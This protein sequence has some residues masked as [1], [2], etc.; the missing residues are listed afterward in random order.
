LLYWPGLTPGAPLQKQ[1]FSEDWQKPNIIIGFQAGYFYRRAFQLALLV[2][3]SAGSLSTPKAAIASP[4]YHEHSSW[5]TETTDG[6]ISST[7]QGNGE[8]FLPLVSSPDPNFPGPYVGSWPMAGANP[9]RTSWTPT[10]VRGRLKP[11]WYKPFEAYISQ[12]VQIVAEYGKLYISTARGLYSLDAQTGSEKWVYPTELSLGH[13]PTVSDGV[14]YV[15]GYDRKIHAIDAQSGKGL[16]TFS[17]SAGFDT[18]PLV[19]EGLVLAGNR[20]GYFYAINAK[21]AEKG[22]LA[23]KFKTNGPILYSA[24]Y[25]NGVVYF[26]SEDSY[27]YALDVRSGNLLWKSDKLPGAGF[28]SWWPVVYNDIVI[29][30]GSYNYRAVVEP[31]L[32]GQFTSVEL[33]D[34][35]PNHEKDP[36]GTL[37]GQLG[38]EPGL[39]TPGTPT[40]NLSKPNTTP[41]G[42][43]VPVTE[44]F[45]AKP[46]RR[47]YLVLDRSTGKEIS[48][49]FDKDGKREYAPILW[50]G[51]QSG[52]RYP[53]AVG[54]DS[55]L[56]QGNNYRSDPYIAGGHISGWVPGSPYISVVKSGW[57]AVDEPVAFA[58]G[59]RLLYWNRCCDRIAGAFDVTI[60][61]RDALAKGN[62]DDPE[63]SWNY[64]SY[65]LPQI[66]PGYNSMTYVT[67]P[68]DYVFGGAYGGKNGSYGFHG[69]VNPPI[70]YKGM[71]FMHRSNAI[72]A[73]G[74][75]A[76]N[77]VKLPNA[78][79]VDVDNANIPSLSN[80]QIKTLLKTEIKKMIAAGHL[81]PGYVNNGMFDLAARQICGPDLVDYFHSPADTIYTLMLA[82]PYLDSATQNELAGYIKAE[83][84]Q[85][86]PYQYE[87]IGWRDGSGREPFILPPEVNAS[88]AGSGP[89]TAVYNFPGWELSPFT[90]YALWKYAYVFGDARS[91]FNSAKARLAPVPSDSVLMEMPYIHNAFI[92]GY[93]GYLELE[94]LA[95]YPESA[96]IRT[97]LNQLIDFRVNTFSK[98]A[99][100]S[101]FQ[102]YQKPYCRNL[103]SSRNFIFLV[104]ELANELR[105]RALNK[106]NP[107]IDEYE[108]INPLWFAKKTET[109]LG[110]G[111]IDQLYT[112]NALF[113]AKALIQGA[114]RQELTK[115]LD[116][117]A[118]EVGDLFYIQNLV[119]LIGT[120]LQTS[121]IETIPDRP[122]HNKK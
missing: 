39:W 2:V 77:P 92:A 28:H 9:Q 117:P 71:V 70:P 20:D 30:S 44:Y 50:L 101:Y 51:T 35:Y 34:V 45:E 58:A 98:D 25:Q 106:V 72:I 27:A 84:R 97:K 73:F 67:D 81:R 91:L 119:L 60:P 87:H 53:P 33:D 114:S 32:N 65:N 7:A 54:F 108:Q 110:E 56:Y 12:K 22:Q 93:L 118:F 95:G 42:R 83:M 21:G 26:A 36:R 66:V 38:N 90:F 59:G 6:A 86:P 13:S 113:K 122:L 37:V 41:N 104:P 105:N 1:T 43:T 57:N 102:G 10:E 8:V 31:G 100:D 82:Y 103:T 99:P 23:W 74:E 62:L 88:M 18:N 112:S 11:V 5:Q 120:S 55:V 48:Y 121:I 47:T 80:D 24:A 78:K 76:N 94:A 116:I 46:W 15:G 4:T 19:V 96:A 16:W 29:F 61:E 69:D 49:D 115:Y 52:N 14:V 107:A 63:R 109:V 40:I 85:F 89:E 111:V 64:F 75:T 79:I 17:A 68:Y 3:F